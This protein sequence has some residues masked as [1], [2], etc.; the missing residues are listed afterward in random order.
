MLAICKHGFYLISP[1][2]HHT[3]QQRKTTMGLTERAGLYRDIEEHRG[4]PLMVYVTSPRKGAEGGMAGDVIPEFIDQIQKLPADARELDLFIESNGGDA[5]TAWRVMSLL[6]E[7]VDK[8]YV[9]IPCSAFS[10]ATLMALGG[11]EMIL[12][13]Y[14]CLGPID[15]QITAKKSDGSQQHFGIP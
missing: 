1:K 8:I 2:S 6:R 7:R 5:L 10:A 15:P 11:D 14:G 12:G 4:R 9:L 3:H 13:K